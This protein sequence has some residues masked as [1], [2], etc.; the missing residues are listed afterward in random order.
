MSV[1]TR[2]VPVTAFARRG[3]AAGAVP[4]AAPCER[5][6]ENGRAVDAEAESDAAG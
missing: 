6:G 5:R 4:S 2:L 1:S 3:S